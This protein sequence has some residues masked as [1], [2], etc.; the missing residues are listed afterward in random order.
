MKSFL[1][2]L[3]FFS[4]ISVNESWTTSVRQR[5]N[6]DQCPLWHIHNSN[7]DCE[8]GA[9]LNGVIS[10]HSG[11]KFVY[12]EN[13]Y[14]LTWNNLTNSEDLYRCLFTRRMHRFPHTSDRYSIPINMSG[15]ELNY[16]MCSSFNVNK[17]GIQC[18]QCISGYGPAMF[19]DSITCADCSKHNYSCNQ[20]W[21]LESGLF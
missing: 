1:M 11:K 14:C 12:V 4:C 2:A 19:L 3:F 5:E 16:R 20:N 15:E 10:C 6:G 9:S 7:G 21:H 18:G 13:G 8:C 17:Q